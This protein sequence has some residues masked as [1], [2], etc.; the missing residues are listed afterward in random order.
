MKL[1]KTAI[2]VSALAAGTFLAIAAPLSASA[3]IS[4]D[5]TET[6]AG[7]STVITFA[8]PHGCDGSATTAIRID[9]PE[10]IASVTPTAKPDWTVAEVE[11]ELDTPTEDAEGNPVTT[12]TQ[13]VVYTAG[14]PLADGL[15]D[16]FALSLPLPADAAGKTLEFPVLQTCEQG[17]TNWNETTVAG[18]DEPA[19]PAPAI[20]VTEATGD[21][22]G[23]GTTAGDDHAEEGDEASATSASSDDVLARVLGIGGLAV[24]AVGVVLAVTARRK[25]SA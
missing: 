21:E 22:H 16:T 25:T 15:R 3:H 13:T 6:A 23:Q 1:T 10:G 5:P 8:L 19:H 14:T 4:V 2:T 18:E 12:R 20:T 24:G 7:S 11:A 17:E 9:I